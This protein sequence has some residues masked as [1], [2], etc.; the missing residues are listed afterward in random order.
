MTVDEVGHRSSFYEGRRVKQIDKRNGTKYLVHKPKYDFHKG[1][2]TS[3]VLFE[4]G[5]ERKFDTFTKDF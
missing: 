3:F 5:I 4:W 1:L 2:Y